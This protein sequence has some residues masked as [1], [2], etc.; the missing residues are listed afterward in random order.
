MYRARIAYYTINALE[1]D[2]VFVVKTASKSARSC[3]ESMQRE[4]ACTGP[5]ILYLMTC[6]FSREAL[7]NCQREWHL[8]II[9]PQ[10]LLGC[11]LTQYHGVA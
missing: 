4:C 8:H 11:A 6:V 7:N 2:G 10:Q 1:L 9:S 5:T 3:A